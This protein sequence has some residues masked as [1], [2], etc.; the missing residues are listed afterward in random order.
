MTVST[1]R[2][3]ARIA[4]MFDAIAWRY[5]RLNHLLSLGLDR[6]W[7][8]RAIRELA[9]E[10]GDRVLDVCTGTGDLAIQATKRPVSVLGIDFAGEMLKHALEK[11]RRCGLDDRIRLA[12][13]DAMRLPE[14]LGPDRAG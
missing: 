2:E 9:L 7:R 14:V 5:D 8:R 4:G 6:V 12:R 11:V 10:D 3:P 1:S 13:G